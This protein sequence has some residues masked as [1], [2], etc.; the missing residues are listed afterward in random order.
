LLD[1]GA[2]LFHIGIP[3]TGTTFIQRTAAACRD[4]LAAHGVF[5][6]PG[7][8]TSYNHRDPV[9]AVL[10]SGFADLRAPDIGVWEEF[11]ESLEAAGAVRCWFGH[12]RASGANE[13]QARY[14]AK[15]LGR[16]VHVVITLRSFGSLLAPAWSE[17][18]KLRSGRSLRDFLEAVMTERPDVGIS[19]AFYDRNDQGLVVRR[20]AEAVGRE[21]VTAIVVDKGDP[22][23]LPHCFE[24]LL[25]LPRDLLVGRVDADV[26]GNRSLSLEEAELNRLV[27]GKLH[28]TLGPRAYLEIVRYGG[29]A[30]LLNSE[31]DRSAE[32]PVSLPRDVAKAATERGRRHADEIAE[33]GVRVLGNLDL[34]REETAWVDDAALEVGA[35]PPDLAVDAIAGIARRVAKQLAVERE[36]AAEA[37]AETVEATRTRRLAGIVA[38]R[39]VRRAARLGRGTEG[40]AR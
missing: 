34:L 10:G 31:R 23:Y 9:D 12:E 40:G 17:S 15:S 30:S 5:Y 28:G 24:D 14:F 13:E 36:R 26:K 4:Q 19:R 38:G 27:A 35:V 6:P 22:D 29:T 32:R 21:N 25:G 2:K 8:G 33:S 18:A 1:Q 16:K 3:K 20:W 11:A 39:L 37:R 7:R